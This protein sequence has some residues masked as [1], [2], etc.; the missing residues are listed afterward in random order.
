MVYGEKEIEK[1]ENEIMPHPRA[2]PLNVSAQQQDLLLRM[3]RRATCQERLVRRG[4]I[5]LAAAAEASNTQI[6]QDLHVDHETVRLW[7]ERRRAAEPRLQTIEAAGKPKRLSEAIEILLTDEQRPGAPGTF[8]FEQYIET[9]G[10]RLR[11]PDDGGPTGKCLD[12]TRT[13]RRSRETRHRS[14]HFS[15][16]RGTFFKR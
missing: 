2:I 14:H 4:K 5:I 3:V 15:T 8:T 6:T 12:A 13:R 11:T 9:H 1:K 16:N 7:R 10:T